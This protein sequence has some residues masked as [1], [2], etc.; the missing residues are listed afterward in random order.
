MIVKYRNTIGTSVGSPYQSESGE[1]WVGIRF[2][3]GHA[4]GSNCVWGYDPQN[5]NQLILGRWGW[6]LPLA[7]LQIMVP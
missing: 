5:T 4:E 1:W 6:T 2:G 3:P 7:D